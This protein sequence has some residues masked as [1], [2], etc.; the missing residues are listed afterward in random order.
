MHPSDLPAVLCVLAAAVPL[1]AQGTVIPVTSANEAAVASAITAANALAFQ[2]SASNPVVIEFASALVGQTVHLTQA[3]PIL[4]VDWATVRVAGAT[5]SQRVTLDGTAAPT[6]FRLSGRHQSLRNIRFQN[7][8]APGSQQDVVLASGAD[9]LSV[10]DC[11]FDSGTGIGLWLEGV[12]GAV[13]QDSGFRTSGAGLTATGGTANLTIDNC[14]FLQN[15]RGLVVHGGTGLVVTH[16]TFDAN[17]KAIDLLPG[18]VGAV[19]GPGNLLKNTSLQP[20]LAVAAAYSL[21]VQGNQFQDNLQTAIALVDG[22]AATAIRDNV[23]LRNGL[24]AIFQVVVRDSPNVTLAGNVCNDGGAGIFAS[25]SSGL[26]IANSAQTQA[27]ANGNRNAAVSLLR[28]TGAR[29]RQIAVSGNLTQAAGS[30]VAAID[31]DDVEVEAVA[32][33]AAAGAGRVGLRVD[34]T[35]HVKIGGGTTVAGNGGGGVLVTGCDDVAIGNWPA[36][37]GALQTQGVTAL[38]I[39]DCNR[40]VVAGVPTAP[41]LVTGS[42]PIGLT[43]SGGGTCTLGPDLTVDGALATQTALQVANANGVRV[44]GVDLHGHTG[45]GLTGVGTLGL[46]VRDCQVFGGAGGQ[47][48]TGEGILVNTGCDGARLLGNHVQHHTGSA[49]LVTQCQEV[50]VGPGNVAT[51]NNGDGI[52]VQ[53]T[54]GPAPSRHATLQSVSVVGTNTAAQNG[55]RFVNVLVDVTNA[56]VTR[57]GTGVLMQAGA[58]G[59]LVN[60]ISWGNTLDRNRDGASTGRWFSGI[61]NTTAGISGPGVWTEQGT[62]VGTDPLFVAPASG[63]VGLSAGSPAIDSGLHATP[64]G[65]HLPCVD[66]ALQPR[67]RGGRVDMGAYEFGTLANPLDL[68]G[69]WLRPPTQSLLLLHIQEPQSLAGDTYL[70]MMSGAG[71]G[72]G[73]LAPTGA[74]VPLEA[75]LWTGALLSLPAFCL[76]S[77][78]ATGAA[79]TPILIPDVL[80]PFLPEVTFVASFLST[81]VPTNPVIVRFLL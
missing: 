40:V 44:V 54:P 78:D 36:V 61:R 53:D 71:T 33:G 34:N 22:C 16:C 72:S 73:L 68:P 28:C 4:V 51:G 15:G 3:L 31:S 32:I 26:T 39:T 19:I 49:F 41:V 14:Q 45:F 8:G 63:D 46:E 43:L 76:G 25:D 7:A 10:R 38:Q 1:C 47:F 9:F 81:T 77:L 62:L 67:I 79:N 55:L 74:T 17:T 23:L 5:S 42:G 80:L 60:V 29:I 18:S 24:P 50:W 13:V 69:E 70:L 48:A 58:N 66:A 37:T 35:D 56:T 64:P 30:Q 59:D 75:D 57:C 12:L 2:A 27:T 6:V 11:D 21:T 65:S 52:T 20:A